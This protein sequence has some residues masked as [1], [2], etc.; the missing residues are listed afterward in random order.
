MWRKITTLK[1]SFR[2]IYLLS[3]DWHFACSSEHKN[4]FRFVPFSS[5]ESAMSNVPII[6]DDDSH[7]L[8]LDCF[9]LLLSTQCHAAV[10]WSGCYSQLQRRKIEPCSFVA[11]EHHHTLMPPGTK[12]NRGIKRRCYPPIRLSVCVCVP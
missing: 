1:T 11:C 5:V 6:C 9:T 8:L 3:T 2:P 7:S 4:Y 12:L 10:D